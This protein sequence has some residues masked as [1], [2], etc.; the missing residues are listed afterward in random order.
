MAE[1]VG[2]LVTR[3][4]RVA[5]GA[6]LRPGDRRVGLGQLARHARARRLAD[7][8]SSSRASFGGTCLN[9]GCIPTKMFVYPADLAASAGEWRRLGPARRRRRAC[10]WP[11]IRDRVF[12]R[13]DPISAGGREYRASGSPNVTLYEAHAE[14]SRRRRR[15][16]CRP[17]R[18]SPPTRSCSPP[19]PARVAPD[20][21]DAQRRAVPHVRHDHAHRRR[22]PSG[23][24]SSAAAT[25]RPSSRTSSPPSACTPPSIAA[26]PAAARTSTTR[27]PRGSPSSSATAGTCAPGSW[28]ADARCRRRDPTLDLTDGSTVEADLLLVATGRVPN[29]DRLNLAA[30]R[31]RRAPGRPDHGRRVPAHVRAGRVGARR[32]ARR[33]TSSSTSPTTRHASSRTTSRTRTR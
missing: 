17:A 22:C 24:S 30:G 31:R 23:W 29:G 26:R 33:T 14:F 11:D 15:C 5:P 16:A 25:S 19:A 2:A 20:V 27:S 21:V 7:R 13:I 28:R 1:A 6:A 32:R 10:D 3:R 9:V 12:G 4:Y 8:R 18:R